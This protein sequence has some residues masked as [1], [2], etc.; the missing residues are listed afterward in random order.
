MILKPAVVGFHRIRDY[1]GNLE[2]Q[3]EEV[4]ILPGSVL[5]GKD[6]RSTGIGSDLGI[7]IA[8]V[9]KPDGTMHVQSDVEDGHRIRGYVIALGE[10]SKLKTLEGMSGG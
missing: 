3:L 9:K 8:A 10:I 2:I 5:S 4:E 6:A 7:I 1:G